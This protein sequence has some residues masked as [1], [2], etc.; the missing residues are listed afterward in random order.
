MKKIIYA[1]IICSVSFFTSC[2]D[3]LKLES[4]DQLT[5]ENYWRDLSDAEAGLAAAY[6]QLEYSIDT[7]EFSE[8][9]WPVEAYREDLV[10]L[11]SD[12]Y[13]YPNWVEL[14]SF[15]FT[16]GNS[17]ISSYWWNNYKGISF[18]NQ[19]I[20][21]VANIPNDGIT[22][23]AR[24]QIINE[25]YFLRAYYHLKLLLNWKEIIIRD[26]YV[27]DQSGMSKALSTRED[28]WDFIIRDLIKA[29]S[30]PETHDGD[31]VGRATSGAAY[32]YL[33]FSYLTRAY[34]E[35]SKK[36]EYLEKALKAFEDIKGYELESNFASMFNAT[37]KNSKESI[38]ELQFTMNSANGA[39]Y[40]TQFHKWMA[41]SELKGWDEIL[42]SQLL[43]NEFMKEG[44]IAT[45]GLYDSRLYQTI[46][47]QCDYFN[48]PD[49]KRVYGKTYDE[50]FNYKETDEN[51]DPI[52]NIIYYNRYVFHKFLPATY[53][54]L[55]QSR[56]A[57]N[58]PL[59]RYANV[60]LMKAEALNELD[61]TSEAIPIINEVRKV[62]G[63]MPPMTGTTKEE[64]AAQIEHERMLEFPLENFRWYDLRRWGKLTESLEAVGRRTNF[65]ESEHSFYPIPL[66]ELNTNDQIQK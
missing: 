7:W 27:T 53:S 41:C 35:A 21:K 40:R 32:S 9:K 2:E 39:D 47:Y 55:T 26:K 63:D 19:I 33:G 44:E 36:K 57:I 48:D 25:A 62:H 17:Q 20:E 49:E 23:P 38:F 61:R 34:E 16:G 58:I 60:L 30:L 29:T 66:T 3:Y 65:K 10:S 28:A 14:A 4:P 24:S 50:W 18:A 11:G 46:L 59:M 15:T 51:G 37:N 64:V 31:N 52:G 5:L 1:A 54:E 8:V 45:T 22:E 13:N 42:P 43:V 6:S 12:A 56:C